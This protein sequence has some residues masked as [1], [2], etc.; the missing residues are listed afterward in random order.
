MRQ[1]A[2]AGW[3]LTSSNLS[4]VRSK[5]EVAKK[6]ESPCTITLSGYNWICMWHDLKNHTLQNLRGKRTARIPMHKPSPYWIAIKFQDSYGST[7]TVR[8][9]CM[10]YNLKV[11]RQRGSEF[12]RGKDPPMTVKL[13]IQFQR[14]FLFQLLG[15][16]YL[17]Y[18]VGSLTY[19]WFLQGNLSVVTTLGKAICRLFN[20]ATF[21]SPSAAKT[22]VQDCCELFA[23]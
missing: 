5:V 4:Q 1:P 20:S 12:V 11:P 16:S 23:S 2:S 14:C 8:R 3:E 13:Q 9:C 10:V 17:L 19:I 22:P 15:W 21:P 7:L 6:I 18:F